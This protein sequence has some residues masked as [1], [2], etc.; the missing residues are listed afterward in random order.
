MGQTMRKLN[1]TDGTKSI[2]II[3]NANA[4]LGNT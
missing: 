3:F 1:I 2:H 4:N